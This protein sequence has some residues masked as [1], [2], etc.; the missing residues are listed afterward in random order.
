MAD[1]LSSYRNQVLP[2]KSALVDALVT[3][4]PIIERNN[5]LSPEKLEDLKNQIPE[6]KVP[7][8][9]PGRTPFTQF[10]LERKILTRDQISD[11]DAI[12]RHQPSLPEFDL[13][14]KIGAGGMGTV[15]LA[16]HIESQRMVALKTINT[17]LA[18]D[19]DFVERFHRESRAL[20]K[21]D[22]PNVAQILGSGESDRQCWLAMEFI[23]G[24]SLMNL[25]K[26]HKQL[27]EAYAL[28][29]TKQIAMGLDHV[30]SVAGLVH[31]DIKPENI[32]VIRAA[33][34]VATAFP[35]ND[36]AKLIDFGLVK[37]DHE[38]ERLT[39]TGMTI[40]TPLYMSP[41][42]V[43]GEKLD[44]R[45]D[46][47]GL[48]AT[49]FHLLTGTTPYLGSSPGAIMSAHLTEAIPDPANKVANLHPA[50][51]TLVMTS[52]AKQVEKRYANFPAFI[53]ACEA[54]IATLDSSE[55][56]V[57]NLMRKPMPGGKLPRK[58]PNS[59]VEAVIPLTTGPA[60]NPGP[61]E[62]ASNLPPGMVPVDLPKIVVPPSATAPPTTPSGERRLAQQNAATLLTPDSTKD[63]LK[64]GLRAASN[65][66]QRR[67]QQ[68]LKTPLGTPVLPS[69]AAAPRVVLS[70]RAAPLER[71]PL[72]NQALSAG[73]AKSSERRPIAPGPASAQ[74]TVPKPPSSRISA[75]AEDSGPVEAHRAS[76][77]YIEPP[78]SPGMGVLPWL[79]LGGAVSLLVFVVIWAY[80]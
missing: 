6:A 42:Q 47:Y 46:I 62:R 5:W 18:E 53:K 31:R 58:T 12:I 52:M 22:H 44:S 64:E 71:T 79:V 11:L 35:L 27:P 20:S 13:I 63:A 78:P 45:S 76:A 32:L 8:P 26:D 75:P 7:L 59:G 29:I 57:P 21:I 2:D 24:P 37:S 41:E 34:A 70:Q 60:A 72:R 48:G 16:K 56:A 49:L 55:I 66:D 40:G 43:R 67:N 25:L 1:T 50:T 15:F 4:L 9:G 19:R 74:V 65:E 73:G 17:R 51:R 10:L 39:Q 69:G 54:A 80:F 3:A 61:S 38:D 68:S 36:E 23:D 33:S 30:Y 77:A 28:H 14:R